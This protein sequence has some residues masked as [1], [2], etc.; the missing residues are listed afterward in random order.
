MTCSNRRIPHL[1]RSFYLDLGKS[2]SEH[3]HDISPSTVAA[4]I[5]KISRTLCAGRG[6][7]VTEVE[8]AFHGEPHCTRI[9]ERKGRFPSTTG[10]NAAVAA[11][12][13]MHDFPRPRA[14]IPLNQAVY[15]TANASCCT[16][17]GV[18]RHPTSWRSDADRRGVEGYD[19]PCLRYNR[20]LQQATAQRQPSIVLPH[21]TLNPRTL[22]VR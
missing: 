5:G 14:P 10:A 8:H 19:C 1:T 9:L 7:G 4:A 21:V 22:G 12:T 6:V 3:L 2:D 11:N 13:P 20:S 18:N 15:C 16:R 17:R